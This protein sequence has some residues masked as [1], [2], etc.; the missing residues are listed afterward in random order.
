MSRGLIVLDPGHGPLGNRFTILTD[1]YEGTQMWHL[2]QCLRDEL[3]A[4]GFTVLLT[5]PRLEDDP[6]LSERGELAGKNG[7]LM[8]LSLHSNAPGMSTSPEAYAAVN[9]AETFYS[10]SDEAGNAPFAAAL[11]AAV[12]ST[13]GTGDRGLKTRR[14]P[15]KPEV[16]YYGVIRA[17]A[18]SGC[19]RAFLTEH[20]FH[21]NPAD[22]AF[23]ADLDCLARLAKAEAAVISSLFT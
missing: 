7:A 15:D 22:S 2:G 10:I 6:S 3:S 23:L 19:R 20:G 11:N 13:M 5:R 21:T 14:Y 1:F 18:G 16:D 12:V 17:A 4:Q 9:G 8:F